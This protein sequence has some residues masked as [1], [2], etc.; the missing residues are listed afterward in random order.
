M[1]LTPRGSSNRL[2]GVVDLGDGRS[3]IKV[4]VTA[5]P[6]AGRANAALLKL[7]SKAL[8]VPKSSLTIVAGKT[9]RNKVVAVEGDPTLLSE[10][11]R[12]AMQCP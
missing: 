4:G 11:V 3:A 9:D 10:R 5:V 7:L 1:R 12:Q 6:E 8:K 2:Q